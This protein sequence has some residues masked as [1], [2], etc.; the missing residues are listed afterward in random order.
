MKEFDESKHPRDDD[1]KFTDGSGNSKSEKLADAEK[2]Y[3]SELPNTIK[4]DTKLNKQEWAMFYERIGKI[5]KEGHYVPKTAKG[6][7][8]IQIET[9]DS[10]V[11]V[12]ASGTYQNPKV[13]SIVRFKNKESM[14]RMM[15]VWEKQL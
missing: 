1:G 4:R 7:M 5:K 6:E 15:R 14:Y 3:N 2:I 8:L 9:K 11:L 13:K 10:N 12:F